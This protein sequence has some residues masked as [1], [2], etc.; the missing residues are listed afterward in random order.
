MILPVVL[1]GCR[2]W[3]LTVREEQRLRVFE[4]M[5]LRGRGLSVDWMRLQNEQL[6]DLYSSTDS[7]SVN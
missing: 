1:C 5:G 3:P 2:A 7:I 6:Y 4:N